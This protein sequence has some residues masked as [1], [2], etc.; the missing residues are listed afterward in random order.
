MKIFTRNP[1]VKIIEDL[2]P[3]EKLTSIPARL[4][5]YIFGANNEI[6]NLIKVSGTVTGI[7]RGLDAIQRIGLYVDLR[8]KNAQLINGDFEGALRQYSGF[9]D[10]GLLSKDSIGWAALFLMG[11]T[12]Y[13]TRAEYMSMFVG[14]NF[15]TDEALK[16][17]GLKPG[18]SQL[19]I[20]SAYRE[21]SK[22]YNAD[23]GSALHSPAEN[24]VASN[25]AR[26]INE[27][28]KILSS[29]KSPSSRITPLLLPGNEEEVVAREGDLM[30]VD[31]SSKLE[32]PGVTGFDAG[33]AGPGLTEAPRVSSALDLPQF[34]ITELRYEGNT[35][36]GFNRGA[37]RPGEIHLAATATPTVRLHEITEAV[38]LG[39]G[40][41]SDEAHLL[42]LGA[43]LQAAGL[44][45]EIQ[46][47]IS[48]EAFN[49]CQSLGG[50]EAGRAAATDFVRNNPL[51]ID[52]LNSNL[53]REW[54]PLGNEIVSRT[55]LLGRALPDLSVDFGFERGARK[56]DL[57]AVNEGLPDP[58]ST[59][60]IAAG[61]G[62]NREGD[63]ARID[64]KQIR[65]PGGE[66]SGNEIKVGGIVVAKIVDGVVKPTPEGVELNFGRGE[67]NQTLTEFTAQQDLINEAEQIASGRVEGK[68]EMTGTPG[69]ALNNLYGN[70][71][72]TGS[73]QEIYLTHAAEVGEG[74]RANGKFRVIG[75]LGSQG[76]SKS[77][78][79]NEVIRLA[80]GRDVI[81]IEPSEANAKDVAKK[82]PNVTV[83]TDLQSKSISAPG[84]PEASVF[85]D[86]V[87]TQP[88]AGAGQPPVRI[89]IGEEASGISDSVRESVMTAAKGLE[90]L[91]G[92]EAVERDRVV[93][94]EHVYAPHLQDAALGEFLGS[95]KQS[96]LAEL[97]SQEGG[98]N[99]IADMTANVEA[100]AGVSGKD[101]V[102]GIK[103]SRVTPIAPDGLAHNVVEA[104]ERGAIA[105][106]YWYMEKGRTAGRND[107]DNVNSESEY[108][109]GQAEQV[110]DMD[111]VLRMREEGARALIRETASLDIERGAE[112]SAVFSTDF[113]GQELP[114]VLDLGGR[115]RIDVGS[116]YSVVKSMEEAVQKG[117][118][119]L[120]AKGNKNGLLLIHDLAKDA[121]WDVTLEG[122]RQQMAEVGRRL[123][124]IDPRGGVWVI[125]AG[126]TLADAKSLG[127]IDLGMKLARESGKNGTVPTTLLVS[128]GYNKAITLEGYP[129]SVQALVGDPK[130]TRELVPQ[131]IDR[132][133]GETDV[134]SKAVDFTKHPEDVLFLGINTPENFSEYEEIMQQNQATS[135]AEERYQTRMQVV[136]RLIF[137]FTSEV[138]ER[139]AI[140]A[141]ELA[142]QVKAARRIAEAES[143]IDRLQN[144][145]GETGSAKDA[146]QRS[147]Q[148]KVEALRRMFSPE[149][150]LGKN[151]N[152]KAPET[153]EWIKSNLFDGSD[154]TTINWGKDS[155]RDIGDATAFYEIKTPRQVAELM[156][157]LTDTEGRTLPELASRYNRGGILQDAPGSKG[158]LSLIHSRKIAENG[159]AVTVNEFL[160]TEFPDG[161]IPP[162]AETWLNSLTNPGTN[163]LYDDLN[164]LYFYYAIKDSTPENRV[165][166]V[167]AMRVLGVNVLPAL[168]G[169]KPVDSTSAFNT[170]Q[171]LINTGIV[172]STG[173]QQSFSILMHL[174]QVVKPFVSLAAANNEELPEVPVGE[175]KAASNSSEL[176]AVTDL[177]L[178]LMAEK[179]SQQVEAIRGLL[180]KKFRTA[181]ARIQQARNEEE[182]KAATEEFTKALPSRENLAKAAVSFPAISSPLELVPVL[183]L[184]TPEQTVRLIAADKG[185][186]ALLPEQ[187]ANNVNL[188]ELLA[189]AEGSSSLAD[190]VVEHGEGNLAEAA[191]ILRNLRITS[192]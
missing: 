174:G 19:E 53:G 104:S 32:T 189:V 35:I 61:V 34:G 2:N 28:F 48:A 88:E 128:R 42:S 114:E 78:A 22:L 84:N 29:N 180:N 172:D 167:N 20:K 123:I 40:Y 108:R 68:I 3:I 66:I 110:T 122:I 17:L 166:F 65:I 146:I 150:E 153:T 60:A 46:A 183:G 93:G 10:K 107:L 1:N 187:Q 109:G 142:D 9:A 72:A 37:A 168:S 59:A 184:T 191:K 190:L 11:S 33:V 177:V 102:I 23:L 81:S 85:K 115:L 31:Q 119:A 181:Y 14:R 38:A 158:V 113:V 57:E 135:R 75:V 4:T 117:L 62:V 7:A 90:R 51:V 179:Y 162:M 148:D 155:G 116:R 56:D 185:L 76:V 111:A 137:R 130:T 188:S 120:A 143:D 39:S 159:P 151:L 118:D 25:Q 79:G 175:F 63:L 36:D 6:I 13:Q 173:S 186:S 140:E 55:D 160:T 165:L 50:G 171:A 54:Q 49:L 69:Q 103:D 77:T 47:E 83:I 105:G 8:T 21:L 52:A 45:P 170:M 91:G 43:E 96:S 147:L 95:A 112:E 149:S 87:I 73:E 99:T 74:L 82:L 26:V 98:R 101:K 89:P 164:G 156:G 136:D 67:I 27:A 163:Q 145:N 192:S 70:S 144:L 178:G 152:E 100:A 161:N 16:I 64:L 97:R 106:D 126:E 121:S 138:I 127:L 71:L 12:Q 139:L 30:V 134:E 44:S 124:V 169:K 18:A 182:L 131:A 15:G 154:V 94:E 125:E 5:N 92:A 80:S 132:I 133:R 58:N 86:K 141:P 157:R 24:R 176:L 41:T 129:D